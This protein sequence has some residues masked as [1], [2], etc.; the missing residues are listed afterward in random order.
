MNTQIYDEA[1]DWLVRNR[2]GTLDPHDKRRFDMWLRK[3]PQHVC[4]YLE[5]S[6]VWEDVS[7]IDPNLNASAE[8]LIARARAE[9]NVF[10]LAVPAPAE[11]RI[12]EAENLPIAPIAPLE[13]DGRQTPHSRFA[14]EQRKGRANSRE[15]E[16]F[17]RAR[18]HRP[19][20][21]AVAASMLLAVVTGTWFFTQ[22]NTYTTG[23]GEQRSIVLSDG[24]TIQLNTGSRV[25]V[26][27]SDAERDVD[28]LE[29]QAL[30]RVAKNH[31]RPFV[32]DTNGARVRAVGTEFD[33]YR[34]Y[35]GTVV[36][37][38]EGKVAVLGKPHA[39][40]TSADSAGEAPSVPVSGIV[41]M[42]PAPPT[43]TPLV[44]AAIPDAIYVTA[45]EQLTV[46]AVI[47]ANAE[48]QVPTPKP[49]NVAAAT[50]WTRRS[51]EFDSTPLREVAEEFNRYNV[52][53]LIIADPSLSDIRIGGTFSS[54]PGLLVRF[55]RKQPE[56]VVE[57]T[58]QEIR[59]SRK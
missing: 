31:D 17:L 34:K 27:Y 15:G 43:P 59:I 18:G 16:T 20:L 14:F 24:S 32:V 30:F 3:S 22:R 45:G 28:L 25:R 56:L 39:L 38:I 46:S 19:A 50:A 26:R 36:T 42:R 10:P 40:S 29:G 21:A 41:P 12:R 33:V 23:I 13:R 58:D 57:E 1:T 51:L 47:P 54:D 6:K 37:V 5:M 55:L 11:P 2:E 49:A 7:F 44:R 9:A 8:E 4:A 53:K 35:G 48:I 52:R